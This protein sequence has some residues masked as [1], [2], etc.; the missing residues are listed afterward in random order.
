MRLKYILLVYS[1]LLLI[2]P[3]SWTHFFRRLVHS[4]PLAQDAFLDEL[5]VVMKLGW[6]LD[7]LWEL[8][9]FMGDPGTSGLAGTSSHWVKSR[10]SETSWQNLFPQDCLGKQKCYF[11]MFA[12]VTFTCGPVDWH[13]KDYGRRW[14]SVFLWVFYEYPG[15]GFRFPH[16]MPEWTLGDNDLRISASPW[17][18]YS[19]IHISY[20][21]SSQSHWTFPSIKNNLSPRAQIPSS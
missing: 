9:Q 5:T 15:W 18:R 20:F 19:D 1:I 3:N 10:I 16:R 21:T 17:R 13:H 2:Y 8:Q 14:M 7:L 4:F 11:L 6:Q 12:E